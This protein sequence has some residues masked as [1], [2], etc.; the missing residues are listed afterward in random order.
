MKIQIYCRSFAPAV[1]GMEKLMEV[2]AMQFHREGHDIAV[3]TETEGSADLPYPVH[4]RPG[5][6]RYLSLCRDSDIILT[7]PLSMRRILPQAL[8]RRP[9]VAAPPDPFVWTNRKERIAAAI[10]WWASARVDNIV[11][12][13]YMAT[14]FARATVI[15]N[16]YDEETFHLPPPGS[17]REGILFVGRL[18]ARKGVS[19]L[20]EA[21]AK[22]A[23]RQ[24]QAHLT[25]V[26]DGDE[27]D[28]IAV[29]I[30]GRGLV[31]RVTLAGTLRGHALASEM[32]RHAIMVVPSITE[33]P[34][35]IVALEGLACG[36]RMVIARSGGLPEAVGPF[37]LTFARGDADDLAARLIEA[38][39]ERDPPSPESV[40]RHL[41]QFRPA[42]IARQYLEA[43]RSAAA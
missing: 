22:I 23:A 10:K 4:R 26:G 29:Q 32:Q 41:Q 36:C 39:G 21:F 33:E 9:I 11:P 37:A 18:D 16:P 2:L 7:A 13:R 12:S 8:S 38:L 27:R 43:L 31:N 17:P 40:S 42:V 34:F 6:A 20:V 1:G 25:I 24:P 5:F 3:V 19:L 15:M 35:G 28:A 30:T 14:R